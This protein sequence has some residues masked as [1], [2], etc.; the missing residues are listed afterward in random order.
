[1]IMTLVAAPLTL[2]VKFL[3]ERFGPSEERTGRAIR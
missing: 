1:L 3:L 2:L